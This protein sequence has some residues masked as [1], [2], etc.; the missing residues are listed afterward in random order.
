MG[1]YVGKKNW[2]K[3]RSQVYRNDTSVPLIMKKEITSSVIPSF[4]SLSEKEY[5][6][7]SASYSK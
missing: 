5:C 1:I 3:K 7:H 4:L 2:L 6:Q